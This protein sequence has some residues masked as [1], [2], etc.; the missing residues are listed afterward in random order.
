[1]HSNTFVTISFICWRLSDCNFSKSSLAFQFN[2]IK[3]TGLTSWSFF[4]NV[5]SKSV[6]ISSNETL[7]NVNIRSWLLKKKSQR[8]NGGYCYDG[9]DW[10]YGNVQIQVNGQPI[11]IGD[12]T[13]IVRKPPF[14]SL[15]YFKYIIK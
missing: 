11:F 13:G 12:N 4:K 1:M 15:I 10:G 6:P 14:C 5:Y 7:G 3:W 2:D 8:A 9:L